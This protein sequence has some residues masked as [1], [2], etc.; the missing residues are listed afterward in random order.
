MSVIVD[1]DMPPNCV[2]C[3]L[4][5]SNCELWKTMSSKERHSGRHDK[6]L[7]HERR[8]RDEGKT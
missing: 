2:E 4:R 6:C 3:I 5:A 7:I 1:L 8:K